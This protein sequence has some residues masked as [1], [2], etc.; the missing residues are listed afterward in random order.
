MCLQIDVE[1]TAKLLAG[2]WTCGERAAWKVLRPTGESEYTFGPGNTYYQ[3]SPGLHKPSSKVV[4]GCNDTEHHARCIGPGA[5]HCYIDR[6]Y[7]ELQL[8]YDPGTRVLRVWIRRADVIAADAE[9]VAVRSIWIDEQD[10]REAGFPTT[11]KMP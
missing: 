9:R 1:E 4:D 11:G 10:W 6:L 7:A 3:Y 2:T 8:Y 5:I